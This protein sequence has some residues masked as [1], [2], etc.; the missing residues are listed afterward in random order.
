VATSTT[1]AVYDRNCIAEVSSQPS[2][3][4]ITGIGTYVPAEFD[5]QLAKM[6]DGMASRMEGA[7]P[8]P[9]VDF[10]NSL[11]RLEQTIGAE[12]RTSGLQTFLTLARNMESVANSLNREI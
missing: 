2:W 11:N 12:G 5:N 10:D 1:C 6:L 3:I 7:V 8:E 9:R 4:R